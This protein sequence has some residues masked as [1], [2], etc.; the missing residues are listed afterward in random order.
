M[1]RLAVFVAVMTLLAAACGDSEGD[2][3]D[4]LDSGTLPAGT[5]SG[6]TQGATTITVDLGGDTDATVIRGSGSA[7]V[8]ID[9]EPYEVPLDQCVLL[10]DG[11][12]LNG[13]TDD[14]ALALFTG[15]GLSMVTDPNSTGAVSYVVSAPGLTVS[16]NSV[17]GGGDV[18]GISAA[19]FGDTVAWSISASC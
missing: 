11:L 14:F 19:G 4:I 5:V 2:V 7:T 16:G 3:R 8:T 18:Q 10:E 13:E 1:R 9:G 15:I 17:S 12:A 6:G